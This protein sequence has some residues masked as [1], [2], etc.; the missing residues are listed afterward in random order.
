MIHEPLGD[1]LDDST[2]EQ[3]DDEYRTRHGLFIVVQ[4]I[5]LHSM[6]H[7]LRVQLNDHSAYDMIDVHKAMFIAQARMEKHKCLGKFLSGKMEEKICLEESLGEC[8]ECIDA[9]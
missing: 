2:N 1:A 6:V 4:S 5:I 7:E 3:Q 9:I 8:I